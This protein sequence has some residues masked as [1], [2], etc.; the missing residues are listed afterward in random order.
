MKQVAVIMAGGK[1]ERFWP[2]SRAARPKQFLSLTGGGRTMIQL[3]VERLLPLVAPEDIYVVTGEGYRALA[4]QQLPMLPDGNILCE[5][6]G[7][8]TA[9]CAALAAGVL[10]AKYEDAVVYLLASDHIV[11]NRALFLDTME[12]A[13][14]MAQQGD[15]IVTIGITPTYPETGYGY[16]KFLQGRTAVPGVYAVDKFV[17]KPDAETA[18]GYLAAGCYLW[19]SGMFVWKLSTIQKS[20]QAFLPQLAQ[21]ARQIAQASDAPAREQAIAAMYGQA[22]AVSVDYGIME[23]A[24]HLYTIPGAFG[25][26]DVG[27]WLSLERIN[28]IDAQGNFIQGN[29]VELSSQNNI[30]VGGQERLL[31][32]VGVEDL[33]VVETED[34]TLI[35]SKAETQSVKKIVELLRAKGETRYL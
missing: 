19:N 16:I 25:W 15:N 28:R 22:Q 18:R 14:E 3:T 30:F 20:L 17:E 32:A 21:G 31:A 34:A 2:L 26:D 23:K 27:S 5:P 24:R 8:N 9:P 6:Q 7:K 33:V 13:A 4:A 1:G 29:V 35:C 11:Q 10:A 12:T